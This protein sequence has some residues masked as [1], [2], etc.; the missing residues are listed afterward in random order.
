M[1][2]VYATHQLHNGVIPKVVGCSNGLVGRV[3]MQES[4]LL[5]I[6]LWVNPTYEKSCDC[7]PHR[8][9]AISEAC[10]PRTF[11]SQLSLV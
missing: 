3:S 7:D 6:N 2:N 1:E 5:F 10:D 9:E 11:A 8:G 4:P